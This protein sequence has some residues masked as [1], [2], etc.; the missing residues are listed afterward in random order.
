MSLIRL[1]CKLAVVLFSLSS[2]LSLCL[3][4]CLIKCSWSNVILFLFLFYHVISHQIWK[5]TV[6]L[7]LVRIGGLAR[8]IQPSVCN[9]WRCIR[10]LPLGTLFDVLIIWFILSPSLRSFHHI[11]STSKC[12]INLF[13]YLSLRLSSLL[14][15]LI[16]VW[17]SLFH[18]LPLTLSLSRCSYFAVSVSG[19]FMLNKGVDEVLFKDG[20]AW[21]IQ[22]GNEVGRNMLNM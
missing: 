18:S 12:R 17:V 15:L 9:Q 2:Y 19:T 21:G 7:P 4:G 6:H 16:S 5:I 10:A 1:L 13:V 11:N 20:V 3:H 8:G 22:I 14:H